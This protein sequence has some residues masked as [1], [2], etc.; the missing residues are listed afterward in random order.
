[1]AWRLPA[2]VAEAICGDLEDEYVARVA[3]GERRLAADLWFWRQALTVR[4]GALRRAAERVRAA[5]PSGAGTRDRGG[6][7]FS[8]LDVKLGLRMVRKHPVMTAASIFALSVGVPA[9]MLPGHVAGVVEVPLPED[10]DDRIRSLRYW[11]EATQQPASPTYFEL[12]LWAEEL[13]TFAALGAF[14]VADYSVSAVGGGAAPAAAA[15]VTAAVFEMLDAVPLHGRTLNRQDE[16]PGSPDVVVVGHDLWQARLGGDPE[17]IGT[18]LGVAGV[19]RTIVGVMPE[20]FLFPSRQQLW[21]PLTEELLVEPQQG[22]PLEVFGRLA[23]HASPEDAGTEVE[24]SGHRLAAAFPASNARL[25]AEVVRFGTSELRL[26]RGGWRALNDHRLLSA[27]ALVLLGIA[28]TNVGMLVFARTATRFRELAIRTALGASRRRIVAQMFI[29]SLVLA[30]GATGLGLVAFQWLAF[31][32]EAMLLASET[33]RFPPYWLRFGLTDSMVAGAL[34]VAVLSAAIAGVLPALKVTGTRVQESIQKAQAGRSGIR[35]G[36]VTGALIVIDVA[37]AV[38]VV[39]LAVGIAGQ[40]RETLNAEER[41]GIPAEEYLA[42]ELALPTEEGVSDDGLV[43][44]EAFAA[45][46]AVTQRTL[47]ERLEADPRVR[48]VAVADRLPR[49]GHRFRR[50]AI[51]GETSWRTVEGRPGALAPPLLPLARV[52]VGFFEALG[53][54]VLAGRAFGQADLEEGVSTAIVNTSFVERRMEGRNP[55]GQRI[56]FWE[57]ASQSG[58]FEDRWYEVVGVV[59]PLGMNVATPEQDAGVYLPAA[60]GEIHPLRLAVHVAGD[61]ESFVPTLR[62]IVSDV[63]PS[64]VLQP[65]RPLDR[66]VQAMW[67]FYIGSVVALAV[68]L[69]ILIALAASGVYAIMSFAVSERTREIG[70]RTALGER[71]A[72]LALR[73]G[74]RSVVQIALGA[75]LGVPLAM[76][77]YRLTELGYGEPSATFG[78]EVAFAA[79]VGVAL[80]IGTLA[81]LSPTR[82][83]LRIEPTEALRGEG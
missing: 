7:G 38:A 47:V 66:V 81:C 5:R 52:D 3:R 65:P 40:L 36:G 41:V 30:L 22:R 34:L 61:P 64:A 2:E 57:G 1:M 28:C 77:L 18:T 21:L 48:S 19:S 6:A 15:Q 82:R 56:R 29:E 33:V 45:R 72:A 74:R 68:V 42:V 43:L 20:G 49:E 14:R 63:D 71:K 83:A 79:G 75:V 24:A 13:A 53:Q 59:G 25:G 10:P 9:S 78:F 16:R 23:D 31:R 70:I 44:P 58:A 32:V 37:V 51:E 50:T 46:L 62:G 8:W 73:I 4:R 76:S 35:F 12:S 55:I 39:G 11:S 54:P 26:P 80:V 60:P 17:V 27:L 67:Y 69:G